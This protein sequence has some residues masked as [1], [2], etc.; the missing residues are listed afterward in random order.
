MAEDMLQ[1]RGLRP[2][3]V[4]QGSVQCTFSVF[5]FYSLHDDSSHSPILVQNVASHTLANGQERRCNGSS[6]R[7][8]FACVWARKYIQIVFSI[9]AV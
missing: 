2:V 3:L 4:S 7:T 8:L 9:R 6:V 1:D 5:Q